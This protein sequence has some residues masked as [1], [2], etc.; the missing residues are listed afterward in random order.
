LKPN[1]ANAIT[2]LGA[3]AGLAATLLGA[4]H[5]R[6][7]LSALFLAVLC[8]RLDGMVARRFDCVSDFGRELD[9]LADAVGFC[10]A[11]ASIAFFGGF[12]HP[13][14]CALIAAY[15]VCGCWRLAQYNVTGLVRDG[16]SERFVGIPTTFAASAFFMLEVGL[17]CTA[18]QPSVHFAAHALFF[19]LAAALMVSHV[20]FPKNGWVVRSL[21]VLL[22]TALLLLWWPM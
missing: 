21:Y 7:A 12:N 18:L 2:S 5:A 6:W 9:S 17:R 4:R 11:P 20:P 8:D 14:G 1:P 3:V 19:P 13:I 16:G 15:F 10:V 22:P